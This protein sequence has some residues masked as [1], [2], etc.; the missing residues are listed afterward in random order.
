MNEKKFKLVNIQE[1]QSSNWDEIIFLLQESKMDFWMDKGQDHRDFYVILENENIIGCFAL[2]S[3][4]QDVI[5]RHFTLKKDLQ[6]KGYGKYLSNI[7]IPDFLKSMK[8]NTIYLLCDN[9]EPYTSYLF[10]RKTNYRVLENNFLV[11]SFFQ[12]YMDKDARENPEYVDTRFA[13]C[14]ELNSAIEY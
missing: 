13:F 2:M 14:L 5:L 8:F 6:G 4:S 9:K 12:E 11:P 10:W 7:L 1:A 3:N